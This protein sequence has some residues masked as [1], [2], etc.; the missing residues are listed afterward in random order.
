MHWYMYIYC[1]PISHLY[2]TV[3]T[4]VAENTIYS[5]HSLLS[6]TLLSSFCLSPTS[7]P[8]LSPAASSSPDIPVHRVVADEEFLPFASETFDLAVT[9]LRW[10][11]G[12]LVDPRTCL[13]GLWLGG[14]LYLSF[15]SYFFKL[16]CYAHVFPCMYIK[17]CLLD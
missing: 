2:C 15:L 3:L 11:H 4:D 5:T 1:A 9:S 16:L 13:S 7:H 10:Q 17:N 6:L 12:R 8:K 14:L